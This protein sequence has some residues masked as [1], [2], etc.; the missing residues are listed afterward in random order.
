MIKYFKK[1]F[2]FIFF[3]FCFSSQAFSDQ[4]KLIKKIKDNNYSIYELGIGNSLGIIDGCKVTT[5]NNTKSYNLWVGAEDY[6]IKELEPFYVL[7]FMMSDQINK[8]IP[9]SIDMSEL[10]KDGITK[11]YSYKLK[12]KQTLNNFKDCEDF[13]KRSL[14]AGLATIA[15]PLVKF[16][17]EQ[18]LKLFRSKYPELT[19]KLMRV[20]NAEFPNNR[21]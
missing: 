13:S 2:F 20:I 15:L 5:K 6:I 19:K 14:Y 4:E 1:S 11:S 3:F 17:T 10:R 18:T 21:I 9:N 8:K 16:S 7:A 12:F